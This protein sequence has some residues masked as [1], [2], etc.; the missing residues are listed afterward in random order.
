MIYFLNFVSNTERCLEG[1][2]RDIEVAGY[3]IYV[4]GGYCGNFCIRLCNFL[5]YSRNIKINFLKK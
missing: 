5:I 4:P 1:T 3:S 2:N